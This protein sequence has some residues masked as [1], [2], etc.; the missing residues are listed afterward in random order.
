MDRWG[1][2]IAGVSVFQNRSLPFA[3]DDAEIMSLRDGHKT[4][5][6]ACVQFK[7]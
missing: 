4:V 6:D 2:G 1:V 3:H 7:D 5:S